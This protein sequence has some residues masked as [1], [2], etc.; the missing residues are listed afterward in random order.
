[1]LL[2]VTNP[3]ADWLFPRRCLLCRKDMA[4]GLIC[5]SCFSLCN[6]C[7]SVIPVKGQT[8]ALF[9]FEFS[10]KDIIRQAKFKREPTAVYLLCELIKTELARTTL[11]SDL[12]AFDPLVVTFVPSHVVNRVMRGVELSYLFA[13]L[14]AGRLNRPVVPM[15]V[16]RRFFHRQVLKERK[17][18]RR[19]LISGSY[20]LR[21]N[22]VKYE[23]VLLLDDVVTTGAT[24]D[25][26]KLELREYCKDI[27]S[28]AIAKTP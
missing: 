3:V 8:A 23:R 28:L 4:Q 7:P 14:V 18:E 26:A 13:H 22:M 16:R 27:V 11:I 9:Y 1:M 12:Q 6:P 24:L 17:H 5:C 25:A 19:H 10:I 20:A 2:D 21:S 15:L